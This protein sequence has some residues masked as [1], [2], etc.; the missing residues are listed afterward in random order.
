MAVA[1]V[2]LRPET[3]F[4]LR[5]E[6]VYFHVAPESDFFSSGIG[7]NS[8]A[9]GLGAHRIGL[10]RCTRSMPTAHW[11]FSLPACFELFD[12]WNFHFLFSRDRWEGLE[13]YCQ[14]ILKLQAS[15]RYYFFFLIFVGLF[16]LKNTL[17]NFCFLR[18]RYWTRPLLWM[19]S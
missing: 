7:F 8:R 15:D 6:L 1:S 18:L 11:P 5:R 10:G 2:F 13:H 17:C 14:S 12:V 4:C 16:D 3:S 9:R 19:N